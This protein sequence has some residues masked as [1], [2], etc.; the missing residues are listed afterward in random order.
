MSPPPQL[1]LLLNQLPEVKDSKQK[2]ISW[3]WFGC[4]SCEADTY[5]MGDTETSKFK[6]P[7]PSQ[8]P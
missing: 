6:S 2:T 5:S 1:L 8:Q 3:I 7:L 4:A